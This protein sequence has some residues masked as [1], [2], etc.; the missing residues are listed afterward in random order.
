MSKN[1]FRVWEGEGT[2][3][4]LSVQSGTK[5]QWIDSILNARKAFQKAAK[6]PPRVLTIPRP[7]ATAA[8][9]AITED[10]PTTP[11]QAAPSAVCYA[12]PPLEFITPQPRRALPRNADYTPTAEGGKE[13][14][15]AT[16][17]GDAE[18]SAARDPENCPALANRCDMTPLRTNSPK[19]LLRTDEKV[20]RLVVED[21]PDSSPRINNK[22]SRV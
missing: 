4:Q 13:R 17:E 5:K 21:C 6:E 7:L 1:F 12:S 15:E 14:R 9:D 8:I 20:K 22:F 2:G 19:L 3:Y 18:N 16:P 10:T 11:V